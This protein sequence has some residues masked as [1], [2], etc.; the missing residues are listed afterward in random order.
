MQDQ[1]RRGPGDP[2]RPWRG[3]LGPSVCCGGWVGMAPRRLR[4]WAARGLFWGGVFFPPFSPQFNPTT[5]WLR[6]SSP[7]PAGSCLPCPRCRGT[8]AQLMCQSTPGGGATGF[9]PSFFQLFMYLT[10][11]FA[12]SPPP[13]PSPPHLFLCL[14]APCLHGTG[15]PDSCSPGPP[16]SLGIRRYPGFSNPTSPSSSSWTSVGGFPPMDPHGSCLPHPN[17]E[18]PH[19]LGVLTPQSCSSPRAGFFWIPGF[20]LD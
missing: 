4:G 6:S 16:T 3:A 11:L 12:A 8:Q 1:V 14:P 5:K 10:E 20:A 19:G 7:C 13:P 15:H 2:T 17:P 9:F 18:H